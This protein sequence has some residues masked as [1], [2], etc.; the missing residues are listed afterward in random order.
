MS[1]TK[2]NMSAT[3]ANYMLAFEKAHG[4]LPQVTRKQ[5]VAFDHS[6]AFNSSGPM[7]K[8][9]RW[10]AWLTGEKRYRVVGTDGKVV[11]GVFRM[12]WEDFDAYIA[13]R[14]DAMTQKANQTMARQAEMQKRA[15][16]RKAR[17]LARE[18]EKTKAAQARAEARA[19]RDAAKAAKTAAKN[20]AVSATA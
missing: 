15:D 3:R 17:R 9:L 19:A 5:L 16:E 11:R 6:L 10:P 7:A 20:A 13:S 4:R 1:E 8:T 18:S 2:S 12:P 14:E